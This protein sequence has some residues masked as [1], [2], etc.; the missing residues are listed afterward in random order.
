M[1]AE[2][3]SPT[4][5][6][7]LYDVNNKLLYVGI[8]KRGFGRLSEHLHHQSWWDQVA[9][10][11]FEH[12]AT[13]AEAL[14]REA[15]LIESEE[16]LYNIQL[17]RESSDM[18]EARET[19]KTVVYLTREQYR[20]LRL[21]AYRQERTITDLVRDAVERVYGPFEEKSQEAEPGQLVA[22]S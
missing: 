11:Q 12:Y 7:L 21:L 14:A 8:T 2:V 22:A 17:P 10:T 5:V 9:S 1:A 20:K 13:R 19:R 4:I 15:R 6:Y 16:P 18:S 3:S